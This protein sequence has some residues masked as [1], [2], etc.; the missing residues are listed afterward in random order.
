METALFVGIFIAMNLVVWLGVF[1][2]SFAAFVFF[3]AV[4]RFIRE[5]DWPSPFLPS[6]PRE[7]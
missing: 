4:Y 7:K 3:F 2:L 1:M 6:N 5:G